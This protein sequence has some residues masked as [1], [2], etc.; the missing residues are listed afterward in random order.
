MVNN[1]ILLFAYN[2][3]ECKCSLR[4]LP[5]IFDLYI[6]IIS[7]CMRKKKKY[8]Y[9]SVE[10]HFCNEYSEH[11]SKNILFACLMYRFVRCVLYEIVWSGK[12]RRGWSVWTVE[13]TNAKQNQIYLN[14]ATKVKIWGEGVYKKRV[15]AMVL[16]R[17]N[18]KLKIFD[19][20]FLIYDFIF[21]CPTGEHVKKART[22]IIIQSNI[23]L[24]KFLY[25]TF[26]C[27]QS[28]PV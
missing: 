27:D 3:S 1:L 10:L 26:I 25:C 2:Y 5:N 20:W 6:I 23:Y 14:F 9:K 17:N 28:L 18:S 22:T 16:I 13:K 21:V 7:H 11:T 12:I 15:G 4:S 19:S 24:T 8:Y